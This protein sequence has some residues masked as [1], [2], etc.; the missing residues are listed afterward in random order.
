MKRAVLRLCPIGLLLGAA[1]QIV[2]AASTPDRGPSRPAAHANAEGRGNVVRRAS[3]STNDGF[4][5]RP[6]NISSG[7][8]SVG[9]IQASPIGA[10]PRPHIFEPPPSAESQVHF[11][12]LG[13]VANEDYVAWGAVEREPGKWLWKQ[14]DAVET[15]LHRAGLKYVAYNWV[16]F[17]PVW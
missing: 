3:T 15:N 17:P 16:H 7:N 4:D 11:K 6:W 2:C 5:G 13:L 10:F 8:L 9:F 14:H 1:A 12:S